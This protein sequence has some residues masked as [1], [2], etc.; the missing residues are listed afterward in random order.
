MRRLWISA[1]IVTLA[2]APA[3]V[4]TQRTFEDLPRT[5]CSS[6][7]ALVRDAVEAYDDGKLSRATS[8]LRVAAGHHP[9][10]ARLQFMLG[11]ALYR[12]GHLR[13]AAEAYDRSLAIQPFDIEA[14]VSVGFTR[15]ELGDGPAAAKH[16]ERAVS[17]NPNEPLARAALAVGLTATGRLTEAV[18]QYT[19][20]VTLDAR[21]GEPDRLAIDIRWKPAARQALQRVMKL[22]AR[23]RRPD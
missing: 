17:L 16:W 14:L 12:G 11:N 9:S 23:E 6:C 19:I 7:A 8:S 13:Q 21:Y 20:A 1:A 10:D 4:A 22:S 3:R 18:E 5:L 15:Y 2:A